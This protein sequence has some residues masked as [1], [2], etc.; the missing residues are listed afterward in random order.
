MNITAE[1]MF[2]TA[3]QITE[4][5]DT[6]ANYNGF[7]GETCRVCKRTANVLAGGPGWF[8]VC[9]QFNFPSW[10]FHQM[11]HEH[12]NLGPSRETI[13]AGHKASKKWQALLGKGP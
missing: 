1:S 3:E 5:A 8:C 2:Y 13:A 10:N 4:A 9:G 7:S 12:P 11:P 6:W